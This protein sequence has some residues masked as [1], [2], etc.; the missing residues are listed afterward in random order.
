[1]KKRMGATVIAVVAAGIALGAV[2]ASAQPA[3]IGRTTEG[4]ALQTN[5]GMTLYVYDGDEV[6]KGQ[7]GSSCN[8]Q[9]SQQWPPF[10]ALGS[11]KPTGDWNIIT[12][13][14]G[15]QWTYKGRRHR[16]VNG[17]EVDRRLDGRHADRP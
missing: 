7:R 13:Q 1:M 3:K 8:G 14:D 17:L 16:Q 2:V 9:C 4:N 5:A 11:D 6:D 15:K 12:R 10:L